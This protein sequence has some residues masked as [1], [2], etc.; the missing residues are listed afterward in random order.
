MSY[1]IIISIVILI[2]V[3]LLYLLWVRPLRIRNIYAKAIRAKG[4][5]V[6]E[7]PFNP[8]TNERITTIRKGI[9]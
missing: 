7:M 8:F 2:F 9:A 6:I 1:W 4:Y 3:A 5:S